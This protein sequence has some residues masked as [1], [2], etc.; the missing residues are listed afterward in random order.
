LSA[1]FLG[2][3]RLFRLSNELRATVILVN[4]H[5]SGIFHGANILQDSTVERVLA[6]EAAPLKR[7]DEKPKIQELKKL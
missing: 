3:T 6:V 5:F 2:N 1:F 4:D 7:A